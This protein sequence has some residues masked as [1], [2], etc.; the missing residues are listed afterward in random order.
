MEELIKAMYNAFLI[1]LLSI[2][3][4]F[5]ETI[6]FILVFNDNEPIDTNNIIDGSIMEYKLKPSM[7]NIRF[8]IILFIND[9]NLIIMLIIKINIIVFIVLFLIIKSFILDIMICFFIILQKNTILIF[10]YI[11]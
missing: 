1:M 10:F 5:L 4:V 11:Y 3:L 8:N 2:S 7:S 9:N 6:W